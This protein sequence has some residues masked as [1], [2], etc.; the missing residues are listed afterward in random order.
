[1]QNL[2]ARY[3]YIYNANLSLNNH[4][5]ELNQ[6]FK[7]NYN[8]VLPVYI[9]P[10]V[11]KTQLSMSLNIKAMDE[12][13]KKAQ[14]II[15]EKNFSNYV[16]D[17]YILLG[18][19]HFYN[20]NYFTASEYLD[21]AA[22]AFRNNSKSHIEA[23]NWQARSLM[24]IS[25][26]SAA[27]I[28]LD[29]LENNLPA[30]KPGPNLA[31]PFATMAQMSIY[32]NN[33]GA[34]ISY[35]KDAIKA[36]NQ[37][38][39]KIRW[40]YVLAQ[41][42]EKQQNIPEALIQYKKV[43]K[44]SAPFEMYFNAKINQ[45]RLRSASDKT[46]DARGQLLGLLKDDKNQDYSDQVY[47][48]IA[49]R[50]AEEGSNLEAQNNYLSAIKISAKNQYQKGLAYLKVADLNFKVLK[51]YLKAKSYYD[52]TV[53]ILPKNYPG[54]DLILK[55][56]QNLQ[57]L[58]QRYQIISIE[59]SLQAIAKLPLQ[60][61][62]ASIQR[63]VNPN[64][65]AYKQSVNNGPP[66][67]YNYQSGA[68]RVQTPLSSFYFSNSSAISLGFSDFRKKWGNRKLETNWRQSIRSSAQATVQDI[69]AAIT[70]STTAD[71]MQM[72][73]GDKQA[74]IETYSANLPVTAE[75]VKLSNQKISDAY[76]EIASYYL[77]ELNDPAEAEKTYLTLLSRFPNN[78]H[79]EATYYSLYLINKT[80]DLKSADEYRSK[81]LKQ[82]PSSVY[83]KTIT[84][85][86]FSLR[87]SEAE[88]LVNRHYNLIFDQ[89]QKKQFGDV[90]ESVN[91]SEKAGGNYLSA[92]LSY[93]RSIA[94]G[95]SYPVDSLINAFNKV[96]NS[97]PDDQLITPLTK[98]HLNYINLNLEAFKKRKIALVDFDPNEPPFTGLNF[99]SQVANKPLTAALPVIQNTIT[100]PL[101]ANIPPVALPSIPQSTVA[102][103]PPGIKTD[104]TFTNAPSGNYYY[105]IHV[106]DASLTLSSSRFG[107]GQFNRGNYTGSNLRHQLKEFDNDQLIFVGNFISFDD[108]KNYAGGITPQLK[109]IMKVPANIYTSFIISKENFD[110]LTSAAL[111]VKY[112]EFYKNNY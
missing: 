86:S 16:D 26:I 54:Y 20:G 80:R 12:I 13:I 18:K 14:L 110:K 85:P 78:N 104:G 59:D 2:T 37:Q 62:A 36:S 92:Q 32:H 70:T 84:D 83:A 39:D 42:Y 95:R 7:D 55:K 8:Q 100:P 27:N 75:L 49:E 6:T 71:S 96:V 57:Y 46:I 99:P 31:E 30:L 89:Y 108:V 38:S 79:L 98:D 53:A 35:L 48:Q 5:S 107:I 90:I 91:E 43:E 88:L 17:A 40:T 9:G 82:F 50:L 33:D 23:L 41:L 52:S 60:E 28:V 103:T 24:Q 51:D 73:T 87:Q 69:A 22:K 102:I 68:G 97:Y 4:Q 101:V 112:F 64:L 105:V 29:S 3:N 61:Q 109:Q 21:Y 72:N 111:L 15:L 19:A 44:S 81:V 74:L 56:T 93:L 63:L 34:A 47:F 1:M 76:Y 10:D 45:I 77:Q 11:D 25:L 65:P 67:E 66:I 94:I 58:T 106:A